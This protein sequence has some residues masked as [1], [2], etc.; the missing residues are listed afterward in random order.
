MWT[1]SSDSSQSYS[2]P[3]GDSSHSITSPPQPPH[4]PHYLLSAEIAQDSSVIRDCFDPGQAYKYEDEYG[5]YSIH[6]FFSPDLDLGLQPMSAGGSGED[7]WGGGAAHFKEEVWGGGGDGRLENQQQPWQSD[8][9]HYH[10][11][12]DTAF[13]QECAMLQCTMEDLTLL[14]PYSSPELAAP[15]TWLSSIPQFS[16]HPASHPTPHPASQ[17]TPP[18][19]LQRD[20]ASSAVSRP[21]IGPDTRCSNCLTSST[22]LWRRDNTGAPVC[23][24]CGLYYKMHGHQRPETMRKDKVLA[25]KRKSKN[26]PKRKRNKGI[27]EPFYAP[28]VTAF[29]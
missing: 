22:S 5:E 16:P 13:L 8:P 1:D 9:M 23:N 21:A 25:R 10:S 28:S 6:P 18:P 15:A 20:Q 14:T 12:A 26:T 4:P 29:V 17:Y 11:T 24:A 7:C 19:A 3:S 2:I 27:M